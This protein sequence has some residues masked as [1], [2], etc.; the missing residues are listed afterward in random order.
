MAW[1]RGA[2][3]RGDASLR[4]KDCRERRF[5]ECISL[6]TS[7]LLCIPEIETVSLDRQLSVSRNIARNVHQKEKLV[8][9]SQGIQHCVCQAVREPFVPKLLEKL[10]DL[11]LSFAAQRT[12]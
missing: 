3:K 1:A 9:A 2:R 5:P 12:L 8:I 11:P 7:F 10:L 6:T 4:S